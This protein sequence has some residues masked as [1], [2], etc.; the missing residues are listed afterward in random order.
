MPWFIKTEDGERGPF[1]SAKLKEGAALGKLSEQALIRRDGEKNWIQANSVPGLFTVEDSDNAEE[2]RPSLANDS[3]TST[4]NK[5]KQPFF[6]PTVAAVWLVS[7]IIGYFLGREHVKY[8]IRSAVTEVKTALKSGIQEA[9]SEPSGV[10]NVR[11]QAKKLMYENNLKQIALAFHNHHDIH[12]RFSKAGGPAEATEAITDGLS[13][14]VH[15]LPFLDEESLYNKFHLDEPWDSVHNKAL[16]EHMPEVFQVDGV[17]EV[18]KTS[19]HVFTGLG[20]PFAGDAAPAI[21]D[22]TDGTSYTLLCVVAGNDKA[23]PWTKP[24][25]LKAD[26]EDPL[27]TLG[28]IKEQALAIAF[29]GGIVRLP[30]TVAPATLRKLIQHADGERV[31]LP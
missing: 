31:K 10:D 12:R 24:G 30:N 2:E 8:E 15:L 27:K 18:G 22:I 20:S 16:I 14:R 17:D 1:S 13:W 23:D 9:F 3:N 29:D 19:I 25:G 4:K 7:T 26:P 6:V 21:L 11:S 5:T 28:Q